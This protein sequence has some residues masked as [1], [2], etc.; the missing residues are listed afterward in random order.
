MPGDTGGRVAGRLLGV[1]LD[2][3]RLRMTGQRPGGYS[4]LEARRRLPRSNLRCLGCAGAMLRAIVEIGYRYHPNC[5][6]DDHN[7][8]QRVSS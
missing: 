1:S 3:L 6:P 8:A 5:A 2:D 4:A 7:P